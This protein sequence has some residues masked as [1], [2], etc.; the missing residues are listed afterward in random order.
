MES[1]KDLY[2]IYLDYVLSRSDNQMNEAQYG[3]SIGRASLALLVQLS[4]APHDIDNVRAKIINTVEALLLTI[5][6]TRLN[7]PYTPDL[8]TTHLIEDPKNLDTLL[9]N[10]LQIIQHEL[11]IKTGH[12]TTYNPSF[13]LDKIDCFIE[14]ALQRGQFN[15]L[16]SFIALALEYHKFWPQLLEQRQKLMENHPTFQYLLESTSIFPLQYNLQSDRDNPVSILVREHNFKKILKEQFSLLDLKVQLGT[17]TLKTAIF[18]LHHPRSHNSAIT[19]L[20]T[21]TGWPGN[22]INLD[23]LHSLLPLIVT[24]ITP[25]TFIEAW[26]TT[27]PD[28]EYN[29]IKQESPQEPASNKTHAFTLNSNYEPQDTKEHIK[30]PGPYNSP[31]YNFDPEEF[32]KEFIHLT[33]SNTPPS[34]HVIKKEPK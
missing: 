30:L 8:I 19:D 16:D 20:A 9:S 31:T 12:S 10:L 15:N 25:P 2:N 6:R 5:N 32:L 4:K 7:K 14:A 13:L 22:K 33:E 24:T 3:E 28:W 23:N 29:L 17:I 34:P 27:L 18:Y 26:T 11:S 21:S 1:N